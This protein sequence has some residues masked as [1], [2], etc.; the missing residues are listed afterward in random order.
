MGSRNPKAGGGGAA[1]PMGRSIG[2]PGVIDGGGFTNVFF[3]DGEAPH[4]VF[5]LV[6]LCRGVLPVVA[7]RLKQKVATGGLFCG[8]L[9]ETPP[10]PPPPLPTWLNRSAPPGVV[11]G[12]ALE[13]ECRRSAHAAVVTFV[14]VLSLDPPPVTLPLESATPDGTLGGPHTICCRLAVVF[15]GSN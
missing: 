13:H 5:V 1:A 12:R 3:I 8:L 14:L 2:F 11:C 10:P 4:V 15:R 6:W 7:G 9:L